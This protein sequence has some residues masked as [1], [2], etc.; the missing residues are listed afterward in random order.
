[1]RKTNQNGKV[2]KM[3]LNWNKCPSVQREGKFFFTTRVDT[4]D[5]NTRYWVVQ[6]TLTNLWNVEDGHGACWGSFKTAKEAM[7]EVE[8][9]NS[10]V[11]AS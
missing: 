3:K 2:A 11:M 4:L 7:G 5:N 9:M 6:S 10:Q 1:M 8:K